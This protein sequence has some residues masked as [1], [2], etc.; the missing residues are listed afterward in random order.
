MGDDRDRHLVVG[1]GP[2]TI[3]AGWWSP[4]TITTRFGSCSWVTHGV[5]AVIEYWMD[6][7]YSGRTVFALRQAVGA[8]SGPAR[9]SDRISSRRRPGSTGTIRG[10]GVHGCVRGDEIDLGHHGLVAGRQ[11]E[12]LERGERELVGHRRVAERRSVVADVAPVVQLVVVVERRARGPR[13]GRRTGSSLTVR[14]PASLNASLS[15]NRLLATSWL[16]RCWLSTQS[17]DCSVECASQLMPPNVGDVSH[18]LCV[19]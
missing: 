10:S 4:S 7:P 14:Q 3:V 9:A 6:C 15:V 12:P 1:A 11:F 2:L 16:Y 8:V 13:R 17:P 18:A 19:E 5:R